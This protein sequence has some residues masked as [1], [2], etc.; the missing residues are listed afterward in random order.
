M[1]SQHILTMACSFCVHFSIQL[2]ILQCL[3]S[4]LLFEWDYA[5][6]FVFRSS[7]MLSWHPRHIHTGREIR[8][9]ASLILWTLFRWKT[10]SGSLVKQKSLSKTLNQW[11]VFNSL[12]VLK[13]TLQY[14][15]NPQSF[16]QVSDI[17]VNF[18]I[19]MWLIKWRFNQFLLIA[20]HKPD[21][22]ERIHN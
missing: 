4:Q 16:I 11:V 22:F 15:N 2:I 14:T 12:P 19:F 10:T 1:S 5:V 17:I 21:V 3:Q 6:H 18:S 8:G 7:D 9:R 13:K 20:V